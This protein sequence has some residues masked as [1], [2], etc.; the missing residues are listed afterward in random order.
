MKSFIVI[1]ILLSILI[2]SVC[3]KEDTFRNT[4]YPLIKKSE[5]DK[6]LFRNFTFEAKV[7]EL[8]VKGVYTIQV[9][10]CQADQPYENGDF[11]EI[12]SQY[13]IVFTVSSDPNGKRSITKVEFTGFPVVPVPRPRP[14]S[15]VS[16]DDEGELKVHEFTWKADGVEL[17][18]QDD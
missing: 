8:E 10:A 4:L 12:F 5:P 13:L 2:C 14:F 9:Y 16:I 3:A 7:V 1:S 18:I 6:A 17:E 15:L 11:G